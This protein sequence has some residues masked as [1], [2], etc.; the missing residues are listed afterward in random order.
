MWIKQCHERLP[1][2]IIFIGVLFTIPVMGGLLLVYP[3]L[4]I[5]EKMIGPPN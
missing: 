5:V 2:L 3:T 4:I 1:Q